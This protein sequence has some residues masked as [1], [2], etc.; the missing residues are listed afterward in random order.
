M[1]TW[2]G[3]P[4]CCPLVSSV[5]YGPVTQSRDSPPACA[6]NLWHFFPG[7]YCHYTL[8]MNE[9]VQ[10]YCIFLANWM[11]FRR[12]GS[13]D[14]CPFCGFFFKKN[15]FHW[16]SCWDRIELQ[17]INLWD[18]IESE[19]FCS[20]LFS[21]ASKVDGSLNRAAGGWSKAPPAGR[22]NLAQHQI[23]T[24]WLFFFVSGKKIKRIQFSWFVRPPRNFGNCFIHFVF[25]LIL[26][27]SK[28]VDKCCA[29]SVGSWWNSSRAS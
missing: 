4:D 10:L 12:F 6:G 2:P 26:K 24:I 14:R 16:Q 25:F 19:M 28:W 13:R 8:F 29:W 3:G 18:F 21:G 7:D 11:E 23:I 22:I 20:W 17:L 1:L 15:K 5:N 27:I 9:I